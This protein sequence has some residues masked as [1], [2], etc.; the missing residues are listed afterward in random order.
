MN[1]NL[2]VFN[3]AY[4]LITFLL[5]QQAQKDP[6]GSLG[7]GF[8]A[9][10][11]WL[12]AGILL[13][14][15]CKTKVIKIKT[16]ADKAG[17]LTATPVLTIIVLQMLG[18]LYGNG[19]S[20]EGFFDK[21]NHRYKEVIKMHGNSSQVK[22]VEYYK[23]LEPINPDSPSHYIDKWVKDSVWLY[24]SKEGDTIKKIYYQNDKEIS[25]L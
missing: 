13:F 17:V 7:V 2:V 25:P 1:S 12:F 3:I 9:V 10:F 23:S 6:S 14:V 8:V 19:G 22:S 20:S 4:Y 5:Y 21:N 24:F 16:I 11:F 15:L 18:S